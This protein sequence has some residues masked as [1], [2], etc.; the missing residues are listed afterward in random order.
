[1]ISLPCSLNADDLSNPERIW[2]DIY[3]LGTLSLLSYKVA[4]VLDRDFSSD[5]D[6]EDI[7]KV[8]AR[9]LL[10]YLMYERGTSTKKHD[11]E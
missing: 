8:Y 6:E 2:D 1:M 4:G 3:I 10:I 11:Q 9:D 5:L 7:L